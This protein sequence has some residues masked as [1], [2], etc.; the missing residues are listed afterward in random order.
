MVGDDGGGSAYRRAFSSVQTAHLP[1]PWLTQSSTYQRPPI[2]P[3]FLFR[4]KN[5][6]QPKSV[7]ASQAAVH[8]NGALKV[9]RIGVWR[10]TCCWPPDARLHDR[11]LT[12]TTPTKMPN[13]QIEA[14]E[15]LVAVTTE[16]VFADAFWE[17]LDFVTNALDNVK[18]RLYVDSRCAPP[19]PGPFVNACVLRASTRLTYPST[20]STN[21]TYYTPQLRLLREAPAGVGHAGHQ[22]QRAGDHPPPHGLLRGRAQGRGRRGA[23]VGGE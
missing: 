19:S 18:A 14:K 1:P 5:V 16:N 2:H 12:S 20:H 15:E 17:G 8:M 9:G 7:A 6:G 13:T 11:Q 10:A 3:Q 21:Q 22:V 4:E 23:S